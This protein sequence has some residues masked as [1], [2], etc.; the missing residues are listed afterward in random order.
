MRTAQLFGFVTNVIAETEMSSPVVK[1]KF[2]V[3]LT[4]LQLPIRLNPVSVNI[5]S[6]Q[7]VPT[8]LRVK[9]LPLPILPTSERTKMA[10]KGAQRGSRDAQSLAEVVMCILVLPYFVNWTRNSDAK[11]GMGITVDLTHR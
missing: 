8:L 9:M 3:Y 10:R 6:H 5:S 1:A 4:C 2:Q 11:K 7:T